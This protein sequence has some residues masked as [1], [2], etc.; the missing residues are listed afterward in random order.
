M[1]TGMPTIVVTGA[2][3]G[4]GRAIAHCFAARSW[5]VVLVDIDAEQGRLEEQELLRQKYS[6]LFVEADISD[7]QQ[8][9]SLVDKTLGRFGHVD[10][11]CNNAAIEIYRRADE[12]TLEEWDRIH[13]VDLRGVFLC[14][15]LFFPAI[16]QRQGSIINISSVQAFANESNIAAYASAKAGLMGLT[17]SMSR[18][19][20]PL[21]VRVNAVCPGV[22]ETEMMDVYLAQQADPQAEAQRLSEGIPMKRF[23]KPE[24]VAEMVWFLASPAAGYITGSSFVVDGGLL[25]RLAI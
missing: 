25:A 15:K 1:K 3:R 5:A 2:A 21:N 13:N 4:I 9:S 11:L 22:I 10:S 19:F 14:S 18:D 8:V 23:G 20:A 16:A 17:R 12:Y 7:P 24:D 6:V